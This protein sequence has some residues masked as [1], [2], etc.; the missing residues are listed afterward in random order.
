MLLSRGFRVI[1]KE[2]STKYAQSALE[3][4]TKIMQRFEKKG[5][6]KGKTAD[7]V[8]E[9]LLTLQIDYSGFQDLDLVIEAVCIVIYDTF[10]AFKYRY[11]IDI[12]ND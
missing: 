10:D 4:V 1:L 8:I 2:I 5:K 12:A 7:Q 11:F 9:S 3:R 6:L